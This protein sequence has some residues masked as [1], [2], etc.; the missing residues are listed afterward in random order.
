MGLSSGMI[1]F[2]DPRS[3]RRTHALLGHSGAVMALVAYGHKLY[4]S[5]FTN[6]QIL[7]YGVLSLR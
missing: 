3:L 7:T 6:R 2:R 4:S 1:E 5:G